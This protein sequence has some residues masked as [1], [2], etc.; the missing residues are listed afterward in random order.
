VDAQQLLDARPH[1]IAP[2]REVR[3]A[4]EAVRFLGVVALPRVRVQGFPLTGLSGLGWDDD[5]GVLY[6][7]SDEG[8]LFHLR[9]TFERGRLSG[10]EALAAHPLRDAAGRDL[11]GVDADAEGLAVRGGGNGTRGDAR[12]LVAFERRPRITE[13]APDGRLLGTH[14]LAPALAEA[15]AY[16]SG[17]RALEALVEHPVHG[18]LT[19][20]ERP[21]RGSEP[22][23]VA[24]YAADGRAW[25]YPLASHP[26]SSVVALEALPGGALL[27]LERGY[28]FFPPRVVIG[29]RYIGGLPPPGAG[30][31]PHTLVVLDSLEGWELDNFEGLARHA[32]KRFFMVSDDNGSVWQETLL[33]YFELHALPDDP[34][35]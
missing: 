34:Q 27:A 32:G 4:R 2:A 8:A 16:V 20:P 1:R 24:L 25:R 5:D 3:A 18:V 28:Q 13:H 31:T 17:N 15:R 23:A 33:A 14:P 9:P 35:P 26:R 7:L 21:L 11:Q 22:G 30:L 29:L 12:L 19:V 6:A 10:V